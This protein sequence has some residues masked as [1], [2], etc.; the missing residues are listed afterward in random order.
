MKRNRIIA[1]DP[2]RRVFY[3][4]RTFGLF[5]LARHAAL[6]VFNQGLQTRPRKTVRFDQ[7]LRGGDFRQ[8]SIEAHLFMRLVNDN[9]QFGKGIGHVSGYR[10]SA[11][12]GNLF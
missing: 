11:A 5:G 12:S 6:P 1:F 10:N 9:G 8:Q 4:L 2:P 3:G 7:G